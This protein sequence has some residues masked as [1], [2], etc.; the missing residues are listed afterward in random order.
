MKT[1]TH[2]H[3]SWHTEIQFNTMLVLLPVSFFSSGIDTVVRGPHST[4]PDS[5]TCALIIQNTTNPHARDVI[6]CKYV[7]ELI[8]WQKKSVVCVCAQQTSRQVIE[9]VGSYSISDIFP[10]QPEN[11]NVNVFYIKKKGR[12]WETDIDA[13]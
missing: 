8:F 13:R 12:K 9:G 2:L 7:W 5:A 1:L 4:T 6:C 11:G 3:R 10:T